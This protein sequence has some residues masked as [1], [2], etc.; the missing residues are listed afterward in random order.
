M[1]ESCGCLFSDEEIGKLPLLEEN[2]LVECGIKII[3]TLSKKNLGEIVKIAALLPPPIE[4]KKILIEN[5]KELSLGTGKPFENLRDAIGVIRVALSQIIRGK[6]YE[7]PTDVIEALLIV[8]NK[9][10][11]KGRDFW[12]SEL[13]KTLLEDRCLKT[14]TET[15]IK[16]PNSI[17]KIIEVFDLPEEKIKAVLEKLIEK[18]KGEDPLEC[19]K[20]ANLMVVSVKPEEYQ[21]IADILL[22]EANKERRSG[23]REQ[24]TEDACNI[25]QILQKYE[26]K[27]REEV[28]KVF[29]NENMDYSRGVNKVTRTAGRVIG[30]KY[31]KQGFWD[32]GW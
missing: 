16:N 26:L 7:Y 31:N 20:A 6:P 22:K 9:H 10:S 29:S 30:F 23:T 28:L 25:Y 21:T 15:W 19:L 24:M 18:R 2:I 3:V 4:M 14:D 32:I 12:V 13:L 1:S 5:E 27:N 17:K 8:T 11:I